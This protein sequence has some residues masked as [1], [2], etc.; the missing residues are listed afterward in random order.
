MIKNCFNSELNYLR[1]LLVYHLLKNTSYFLL[2][3]NYF[4]KVIICISIIF[5]ILLYFKLDENYIL[6]FLFII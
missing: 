5:N 1:N 4:Q 2:I 3:L 6:I